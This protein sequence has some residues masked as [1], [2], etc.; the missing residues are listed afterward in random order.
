MQA[1]VD[2][3]A[4][5]HRPLF[6]RVHRIIVEAHPDAAIGLS[7]DIPTYK[8]GK[9]R[10]YLAAWQHGVSLYGWHDG[11]DGGFLERHPDTRSGK[12]TIRLGVDK[13]ADVTDDDLRA[14]ARAAL[15]P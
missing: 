2:A 14:L 4:P 15:A 11:A 5:E 1:Y 10:L 6:D 13:A 12:G 7:Y 3:I 9:R 8:L